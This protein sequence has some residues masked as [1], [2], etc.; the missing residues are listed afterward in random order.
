MFLTSPLGVDQSLAHVPI[1]HFY[2]DFVM[3]GTA[4]THKIGAVVCSSAADREN[5]VHFIH[6]GDSPFGKTL[7]AEGM[8][9]GVAVAYSFPYASV[10]LLH[11]WV[12]DVGFILSPGSVFVSGAVLPVGK[13]RASRIGAGFQRFVRHLL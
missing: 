2:M 13:I 8:L 5:V 6:E 7:L 10:F 11:F 1:S 12:S 4:E 3:A 9:F